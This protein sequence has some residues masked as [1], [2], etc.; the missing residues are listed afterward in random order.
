MTIVHSLRL[1]LSLLFVAFLALVTASVA[2]TFVTLE[3]Q[4]HDALL[5]NLAGRQRMLSQRMTWLALAA[6]DSAA[7][8]A[9]RARFQ[10]TLNALRFGGPALDPAG[11]PVVL[12]APTDPAL[13]VA[14]A[15]AAA[16]WERFQGALDR[17]TAAPRPDPPAAA[18]VVALTAASSALLNSLDRSV[19][20]LTALAE[21]KVQRLRLIQGGFLL[22]ALGLL[23]VGY[24][25]T[26]SHLLRPLAR[27]ERSAWQMAA[28]NLEVP[29]P[30]VFVLHELRQL[31]ATLETMRR[32]V[33][34]GRHELEERVRHR[35]REL[36]T[37]FEFTQEIVGQLELEQLLA[38]VTQRSRALLAGSAAALCLLD[39]EARALRLAAGSG[40]GQAD[41]SLRQPVDGPLAGQVIGQGRT[42]VTETAC[43]SCGFLRS[44]SIPP[45]SHCIAT[46]LRAG[47]ATL[48]ALCVVRPQAVRFEPE[49]EAALSL[50]ANTAAVAILNA[51]LV[52][53]GRRQA[54]LAAAQ[55]ERERL[56]RNLHDN[57]AQTLSFLNLRADRLQDLIAA[58]A[59]EEAAAVLSEMRGATTRAYGQVRDAL[60]GLRAAPL[61][62]QALLDSLRSCVAEMR[63]LTGLTIELACEGIGDGLPLSPV[64]Q[65]QALHIVREALTNAWR[66]A[67]AQTVRV[68][69]RRMP[70]AVSFTV[71]DDGCGFDPAAVDDTTHLGLTIM[72]ARAERSG[73]RLEIHTR[74]GAGTRVIAT[75]PVEGTTR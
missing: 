54:E 33:L 73:G 31:G 53:E 42:V 20:V 34:A 62:G 29:V 5:I 36:T 68:V 41:R 39:E 26:R 30:T 70:T 10:Q 17:L 46:P 69:V 51:R 65:Q 74:P 56:A 66:H 44:R 27:L 72:R 52:E 1:R 11:Q 55:A 61:N 75:F 47:N 16:A 3:R 14:M 49:E 25:L 18:D 28:G 40:E 4:R 21:A 45:G 32:Q 71:A 12:P 48:G 60:A 58:G 15:E 7:L 19:A 67:H 2:V 23:V 13:D 24:Y 37:A 59:A 8:Q 50:L 57:L 35:T 63:S 22:M 9:D 43:A 38:S 6:A 64:A